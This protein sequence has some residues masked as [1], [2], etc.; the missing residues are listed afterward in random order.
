MGSDS[1]DAYL[2]LLQI[3]IVAYINLLN[4]EIFLPSSIFVFPSIP[5]IKMCMYLEK[6][7]QINNS[8]QIYVRDVY[9]DS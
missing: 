6:V 2:V 9:L 8:Q 3:S 5:L 4:L 1:N 7:N